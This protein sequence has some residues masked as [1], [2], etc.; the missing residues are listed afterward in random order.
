MTEAELEGKELN[1][2]VAMLLGWHKHQWSAE[3]WD[4]RSTPTEDDD[5]GL[6]EADENW[7]PSTEWSCGGPIIES[8]RIYLAWIGIDARRQWEAIAWAEYGHEGPE[9]PHPMYGPT[10]LIAAMRALVALGRFL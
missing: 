8:Q 3:D 10:P 6:L 5:I 7:S 2:A 9:G 1:A 4:W